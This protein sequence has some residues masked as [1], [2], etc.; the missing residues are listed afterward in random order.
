MADPSPDR[1]RILL[2]PPD[3]G[4]AEFAALRRAFDGGW[5]A[6][7]GPEVDAFEAELA[8]YVGAPA[9]AALSSGSAAL[10]LALL[11]VG[12]T[13]GDEVVV[14]TATFAAT[15]FA[16]VHLGATP[17]FCDVEEETWGLDPSRLDE[18]LT[19]RAAAGKPPAAVMTVDLY[20]L[21]GDYEELRRVCAAHDVPLVEDA[22]ESLGSCAPSGMA[23]TLAE[24]AAFSFNG[25]KIMTTSG[26]GAL[27]GPVEVVDRVRH[28]A[29]QA[30]EPVPHFEHTEIGYNYRLSNLLAAL[31]RA[32]LAGLEPKIDR[33]N[34]ILDRYRQALPELN[35]LTSSATKRSNCWISLGLLPDGIAPAV[36]AERLSARGIE[37]R[38]AFKPMHLQP[39]FDGHEVVGG[40]VATRLFNRGL[41]LPSGSTLTDDDQE[42]VIDELR[43]VLAGSPALSQGL[44]LAGPGRD[45]DNKLT[46]A[47][48]AGHDRAGPDGGAVAKDDTLQHNG[49]AA[50]EDTLA[51]RALASHLGAGA[52][53]GVIAD[54]GVVADGGVVVDQHV[55]A[56]PS[57][58]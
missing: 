16:V 47:D 42:Y 28:L 32:Q 54:D 31:G 23:G 8:A 6:P 48:G 11:A 7:L 22:A 21:L 27:V 37:A 14:Q 20:G 19:A 12:V 34:T 29:T 10:E 57:T 53:G 38:Q 33:R 2:S 39:V 36:V 45:A 30:R 44:S 58:P 26:G 49:T 40:E 1:E 43:N 17:I 18:L 24:V 13:A 52:D 46:G 35:W 56:E 15:A 55:P 41:C 25:N 5:I 3:V 51:D 50:D 4:P 9:C